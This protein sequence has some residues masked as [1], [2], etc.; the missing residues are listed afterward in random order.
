MEGAIGMQT[1]LNFFKAGYGLVV[2]ILVFT[3]FAF[4]QAV[5]LGADWWLAYWLVI[6]LLLVF[7]FLFV[8]SH[9]MACSCAIYVATNNRGTIFVFRLYTQRF[10]S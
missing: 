2:W 6:S 9:G 1:Y 10:Y 7:K 5:Y 3:L 8:S 4:C